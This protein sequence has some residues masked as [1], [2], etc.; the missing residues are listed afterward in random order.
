MTAAAK[1]S[2]A[3][4]SV[5]NYRLYF[6]GQ[7]TSL[8]GNWMQIVAELW[9]ILELT[10]SGLAVG[11]ATA[12][13]FTGIMLFGLW[14]G[15][16]ADRFDKRKLLII[17]QLAMAAPALALFGLALSG[18]VEVWIVYALI[19][20]RGLVLAIDSPT[21]QAFAMELVGPER[22]VNAVAL[23]SMLVHSARMAGPALAGVVIALWGVSI[24]FAVNALS[25]IVMIGALVAMRSGELGSKPPRQEAYGIGAALRAV[26][27]KR[28]LR[29]PLLLMAALSTLGFNFPVVI[30]LLAR[31]SFGGD[32]TTYSM[33]MVAIGI[34]AIAGSLFA[35]SHG[36]TG[37]GFVAVGAAGFGVAGLLA[38]V[39]PSL[40]LEMAALTLLGAAGV[41]FAASIN[42]GLQLAAAP[43]MR[44]RV[45]A[46]YMVVFIGSTP[47]GG[48]LMGWL[49]EAVSPRASLLVGALTGLAVASVA[50]RGLRPRAEK[51]VESG[52]L[53]PAPQHAPD[54]TRQLPRAVRDRQD[55]G[56]RTSSPGRCAS[57]PAPVGARD[58]RAEPSGRTR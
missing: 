25:F 19:A 37:P 6:G 3:A 1:R 22:I 47:I 38:T 15:A 52:E 26:R 50:L 34:G 7:L 32:I 54:R 21:R 42:A 46:L 14:G 36:R 33:L 23:N 44:G 53:E 20:V 12:L 13:Q 28:E 29:V 30:P 10:G 51:S 55:H 41:T 27:D 17:T 58:C 9:L 57:H 56:H 8:A 24:C 11:I 2:F 43:E 45:M 35:A 31:F 4:L 18:S 39:A 5:R 16:L 48:P 49:A 40:A